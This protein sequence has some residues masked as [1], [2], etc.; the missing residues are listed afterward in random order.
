MW[1][2]LLFKVG[3]LMSMQVKFNV[4]IFK[5]DNIPVMMVYFAIEGKFFENIENFT[6]ELQN[7]F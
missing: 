6:L 4:Y 3:N 5:R 2:T 7:P 1:I